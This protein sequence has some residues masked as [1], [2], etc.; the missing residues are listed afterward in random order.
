MVATLVIEAV[1]TVKEDLQ[2]VMLEL[3]ELKL[4]GDLLKTGMVVASYDLEWI[5]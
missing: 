1:S 4:S 3:A 2:S 5:A